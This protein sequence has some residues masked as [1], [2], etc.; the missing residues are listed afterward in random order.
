VS[1]PTATKVHDGVLLPADLH[2]APQAELDAYAARVKQ[3]TAAFVRAHFA[4]KDAATAR[5]IHLDGR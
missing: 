4:L 1:A 2:D 5:G 3:G